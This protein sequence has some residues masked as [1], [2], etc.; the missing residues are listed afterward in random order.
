MISFRGFT[1]A[2]RLESSVRIDLPLSPPFSQE[3]RLYREEFSIFETHYDLIKIVDFVN[4]KLNFRH[5][6]LKSCIRVLEAS[7]QGLSQIIAFCGPGQWYNGSIR[8]SFNTNWRLGDKMEVTT[9]EFK[10]RQILKGI[11]LYGT[12]FLLSGLGTGEE[13][14]AKESEEKKSKEKE[15]Q[16]V[17]ATEDLMRE[18]GILRRALLVYSETIPELSGKTPHVVPEMLQRTAKLFRSFGEDYHEKKLEEAHIFPALKKAGGPASG[19][20]D[21]LLDQH[22]RG[23]EIT[24][25]I[26]AVTQGAKLE[27]RHTT[28]LKKVLES[29]VLMYR[30]HAARE[31]TVVFPAWKKTLTPKELDEM[32]DKFEDIEHQQF[33]EDGFDKA[34]REISSIEKELGLSDLARFTASPPSSR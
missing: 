3:S 31:D 15:E 26:L 5:S 4:R 16:E 6:A 28:P 34:V 25:Y 2:F 29:F 12:G 14:T 30:N 13:V 18:H 21:I 8:T 22:R 1:E 7:F 10:R 17:T 27:A 33:G 24:D 9:M 19:L 20:T 32:G 23:R 11:T